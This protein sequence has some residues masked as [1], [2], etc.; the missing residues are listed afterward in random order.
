MTSV[1]N[2]SHPKIGPDRP[3]VYTCLHETFLEPVQKGSKRMQNW[4]CFFAGPV[5]PSISSVSD[6]LRKGSRRVPCKQRC[7]NTCGTSQGKQNSKF[8]WNT[9]TAF[10]C[11]LKNAASFPGHFPS[12]LGSRPKTLALV[13]Q[14]WELYFCKLYFSLLKLCINS[15]LVRLHVYNKPSLLLYY[16]LYKEL[17]G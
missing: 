14:R 12:S 1:S 11:H 4:T 10:S 9:L 16:N 17:K 3:C 2:G 7:H 15:H 6:P 5:W 13:L 8:S